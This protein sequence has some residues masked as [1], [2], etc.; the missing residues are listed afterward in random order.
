MERQNKKVSELAS[1]PLD[2]SR[3]LAWHY[4]QNFALTVKGA[5]ANA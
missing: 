5:F 4:S 1:N 3:N 2:P